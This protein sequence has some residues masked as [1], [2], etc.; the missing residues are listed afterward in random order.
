MISEDELV[1]RTGI[2]S[3]PIRSFD[4]QSKS[5]SNRI[6]I[7]RRRCCCCN[8]WNGCRCA[9]CLYLVVLSVWFFDNDGSDYHK[10]VCIR[11]CR[12]SAIDSIVKKRNTWMSA[13]R[14]NILNVSTRGK[15]SSELH[16]PFMDDGSRP[17]RTGRQPRVDPSK[18]LGDEG[19]SLSPC[20]SS[21]EQG[22]QDVR[23]T[24]ACMCVQE[25]SQSTVRI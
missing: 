3:V 16:S 15:Q 25:R 9:F 8:H 11:T 24:V 22:R 20:A 1:K 2:T 14:M 6:C 7:Y 17:L 18:L 5:S 12:A 4:L 13:I 21:H 10:N 19:R 23:G